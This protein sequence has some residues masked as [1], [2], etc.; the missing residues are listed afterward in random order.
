MAISTRMLSVGQKVTV[1]TTDEDKVEANGH[2]CMI[3][4]VGKT[5]F[6]HTSEYK[7]ALKWYKNDNPG[8][9]RP[10]CLRDNFYFMDDE[11]IPLAVHFPSPS[12]LLVGDLPDV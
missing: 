4:R 7:Y 8:Q 2:V 3:V 6:A 1:L 5:I 10:G 11:V 12:V 9:R